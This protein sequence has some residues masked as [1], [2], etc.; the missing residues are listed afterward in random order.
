M[1]RQSQQPQ[2]NRRRFSSPSSTSGSGAWALLRK[3]SQP[4]LG[5]DTVEASGE[6]E[7]RGYVG[8]TDGGQLLLYVGSLTSYGD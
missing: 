3:W 1:G 8:A 5:G 7:A 2:Q 4:F 6:D